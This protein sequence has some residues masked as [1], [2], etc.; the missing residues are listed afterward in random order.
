[1]THTAPAQP[2]TALTQ[3]P[4]AAHLSGLTSLLL[5]AWFLGAC[6]AAAAQT[7]YRSV[8]PDGR[9][10]FSDRPAPSAPAPDKAVVATG[11]REA[12]TVRLPYELQQLSQKFPVTLYTAQRCSP[13]DSGRKMLSE[14]GIPFTEKTVTTREDMDAFAKVSP[15]N[16]LPFLTIGGQKINGYSA[17]EWGQYLDNAGYPKQS[18]LP[19]RYAQAPAQPLVPIKPAEASDDANATTPTADG[20][21]SKPRPRP[22]VQPNSP[23]GIRF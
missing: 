14:R 4:H 18:A 11:K 5:A 8:G 1:M 21:T 19:L 10:T 20:T 12:E 16:S 17:Q 15:D 7:V 9:I 22:P 6:G 2:S 13:C 3:R 23:S